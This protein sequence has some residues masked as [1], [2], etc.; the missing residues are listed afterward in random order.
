MPIP[1]FG[2]LDNDGDLDMIVGDQNGQLHYFVNTGSVNS[3]SFSLSVPGING[4]DVGNSAAPYL[5]DID[6]NGTLDLLIGNENGRVHYY[7]NSS[8]SSPLL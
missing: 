4:I 1:T 2:D 3:P 5:S 6:S 8:P 7:S